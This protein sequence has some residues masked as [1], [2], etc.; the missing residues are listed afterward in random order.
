MAFSMPGWWMVRVT[1]VHMLV[2]LPRVEPNRL[3]LTI[4]IMVRPLRPFSSTNQAVA[5]SYSNSPEALAWLS[6]LSL[7]RCKNILV[8]G[9]IGEHPPT[10]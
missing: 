6:S 5:P 3:S 4:S 9:A 10:T 1:P 7:N 8:A 2:A